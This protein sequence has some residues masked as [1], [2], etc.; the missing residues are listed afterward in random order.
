MPNH[1]HKTPSDI[2]QVPIV[3]RYELL[4]YLR[5]WRL[6]ASI[7]VV[8]LVLSLFFFLP[9]VLGN[10]YSG[11]DTDVE[12]HVKALSVFPGFPDVWYAT[13]PKLDY[14][15]SDI[16]ISRN[17]S[18]YPQNNYSVQSSSS[19][20]YQIPGVSGTV[21]IFNE[22]LT[23]DNVT[24]TYNFRINAESFDSLNLQFAGF[25][26]IICATF[27]GADSIV[28]E[29]WN[30]TGYLVFPNPIKRSAMF[31]GKYA[32]SMT[33]GAIVI[34]IL[35]AGVIG[36]SFVSAHG[37]DGRL[38]M[39]Y[40]FALEYLG[41]AIAIGYLVS[42]VL[43]GTTGAIILTF[44]MLL[45][46]LPIIDSIGLFTNTEIPESLTYSSGVIVNILQTPYP[47]SVTQVTD[48]GTFTT[49][50]PDPSTAAVVMFLWGAV[51]L[52]VSLILFKRKQ[53]LG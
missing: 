13:F 48:F 43:K 37:I 40:L 42:S 49:F 25:L 46:I 36:L 47:Q 50:Y 34:S 32:A 26:I 4:R 10:P 38:W 3:W 12:L 30:R 45:L 11:T 15:L 20:G 51:A 21:A 14:T 28:G 35:Y 16:T 7:G 27:F 17:G 33:A 44:F 23:R 2:M 8:I 52:A 9:P 53:M 31:F 29:F 6:A 39:S 18:E 24:A 5:S 1:G 22:N 41:A 19:M